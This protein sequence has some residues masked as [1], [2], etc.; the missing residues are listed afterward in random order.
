MTAP[1]PFISELEDYLDE[2]EGNTPLPEAVRDAIRAELPSTHQRPAWW[3]VRRSPEMNNLAKYGLAAAAVVVAALLGYTY[4]VAPNI[5]GPS[6]PTPT[7]SPAP[8]AFSDLSGA[9][10]ARARHPGRCVPAGNRIRRADLLVGGCR[11]R[12]GR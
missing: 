7:P 3:P 10:P 5:G 12:S 11:S 8:V 6:D 1:D 4:L 2:Y 9:I